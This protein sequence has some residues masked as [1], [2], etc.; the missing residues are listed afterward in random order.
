MNYIHLNIMDNMSISESIVT[1]E[2]GLD[3]TTTIHQQISKEY[4]RQVSLPTVFLP[5]KTALVKVLS[6]QLF[7]Y[8]ESSCHETGFPSSSSSTSADDNNTKDALTTTEPSNTKES[9]TAI[10]CPPPPPVQCFSSDYLRTAV[11]PAP[12]L[13]TSLIGKEGYVQS[14]FNDDNHHY[15]DDDEYYA[16][17]LDPPGSAVSQQS[18]SSSGY[19]ARDGL[20]LS[21]DTSGYIDG[22]PLSSLDTLSN[23]Y[24]LSSSSVQ[25]EFQSSGSYYEGG[26]SST[27][28]GYISDIPT[29]NYDEHLQLSSLYHIKN[30]PVANCTS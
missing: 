1:I 10:T 20:P 13:V 29:Q 21:L 4:K 19:M 27:T 8:S 22:L 6:D 11:I 23:G 16:L 15:N 9:T 30:T 26:D 3:L 18:T 17:P 25:E 14:P 5:Q 12:K 24:L 28:S 7:S 2:Q